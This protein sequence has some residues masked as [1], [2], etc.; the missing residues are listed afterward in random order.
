MKIR[1]II[2]AIF[3][4][5]T[6][7]KVF[8]PTILSASASRISFV[9]VP[10]KRKRVATQAIVRGSDS[11]GF[12][13]TLHEPMMP[14][15]PRGRATHTW[16]RNKNFFTRG[17]IEYVIENNTMMHTNKQKMICTVSDRKRAN[18][19]KRKDSLVASFAESMPRGIGRYGF[20]R[21]SSFQ[22]VAWFNTFDAPLSKA[23]QILAEITV[24]RSE[25]NE[26]SVVP[27]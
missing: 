15:K 7:T 25:F 4:P 17:R 18:V 13:K 23:K 10:P 6:F 14:K 21:R 22:S 12:P 11:N 2:E 8:V 19:Y 27:E 9:V 24:R 5:Y 1:E 16:L 20:E 3:K 26:I